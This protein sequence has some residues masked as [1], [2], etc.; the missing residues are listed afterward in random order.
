MKV[1]LVTFYE[2][3]PNC[4]EVYKHY[5]PGNNEEVG[6]FKTEYEAMR[7]AF[8]FDVPVLRGSNA[9]GTVSESFCFD[10]S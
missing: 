1:E 10:I 9:N 6:S 8:A 4:W 5:Y 3:I 7:A 2:R